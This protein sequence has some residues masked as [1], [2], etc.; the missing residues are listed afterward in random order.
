MTTTA[1]VERFLDSLAAVT[2][3]AGYAESLIRLTARTIRSPPCS[4]TTPR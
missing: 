1:A 4:L 2:V 3:R